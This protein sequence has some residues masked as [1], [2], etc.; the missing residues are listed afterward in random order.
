MVQRETSIQVVDT[1]T[2]T[3]YSIPLIVVSTV[4]GALILFLIARRR[5]AERRRERERHHLEVDV[6]ETGHLVSHERI[7]EPR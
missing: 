4:L 1:D 6:T 5:L 7:D 2:T 3:D